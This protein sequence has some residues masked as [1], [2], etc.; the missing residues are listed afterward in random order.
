M[1]CAGAGQIT[2]PEEQWRALTRVW[3]PGTSNSIS[4]SWSR[5]PVPALSRVPTSLRGCG[6]LGVVVANGAYRW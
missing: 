3:D 6:D 2:V 5:L 1:T 4:L